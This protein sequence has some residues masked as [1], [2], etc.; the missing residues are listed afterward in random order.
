MKKD[1]I[2]IVETTYPTLQD[3]KNLAKIL[4]KQN[5]AACIQFQKIES[6]YVW[7]KKIVKEKEILLR[8]KS[9]N[10]LYEKIKKIIKKNHK[11]SVPEILMI[12]TQKAD[13]EYAGWLENITLHEGK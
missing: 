3:A 4:L 12:S 9:K 7:E 10:S 11:Y 2:I 8:I 1:K 5:L 13:D 6:M